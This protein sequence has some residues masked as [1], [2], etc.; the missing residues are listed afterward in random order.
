MN[1]I[2]K[3]GLT[4]ILSMFFCTA[5]VHAADNIKFTCVQAYNGAT[6]T[7]AD[8]YCVGEITASDVR[9]LPKTVTNMGCIYN[10]AIYYDKIYYITGGEGSSDVLG[11]IYRCNLDG[12]GN[13]LIANDADALGNLFLS[14]GCLYYS[15]F[16]DYDN[17]YGRNLRG[18]IMKINLNTGAYGRIVTDSESYIINVLDDKVFYYV[19]G[20]YH[21]MNA[22]G[23]YIGRISEY[24]VEVA[25]DAISGCTAYAGIDGEIYAFDWNWNARWI[26]SAVRY[27]NGNQT[28]DTCFVENV[29]GGYIYYLVSFFNPVL[30][31]STVPDVAMYRMPVNGGSSTLVAMWYVS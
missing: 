26:G 30:Q 7:C 19:D 17:W 5:T 13:E 31:Y 24:D 1:K 15:V 25:S 23:A 4:S 11:Y 20:N 12:S 2:F 28:Y 14:D 8:T 10:F 18:G 9:T 27:V 22:N 6:Y 16:N 21:L 29:T 3:L